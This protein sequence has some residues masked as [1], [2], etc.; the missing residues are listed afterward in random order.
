[1][2]GDARSDITG[3]TVSEKS[4]RAEVEHVTAQPPPGGEDF[5]SIAAALE[6]RL[7]TA[8]VIAHQTQVEAEIARARHQDET[9]AAE[10]EEVRVYG[11]TSVITFAPTPNLL[12]IEITPVLDNVVL[13]IAV[14]PA[15][16]IAGGDESRAAQY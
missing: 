4:M 3:L 8:Q 15:G 2:G 12:D 6:A 14:V 10:A 16:P 11:P 1:M 7:H 9:V 13:Q 5:R